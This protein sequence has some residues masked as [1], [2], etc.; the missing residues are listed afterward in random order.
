MKMQIDGFYV[1]DHALVTV[2]I[3]FNV[4]TQGEFHHCTELKVRATLYS[5][6]NSTT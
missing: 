4:L 5:I 3:I 2:I 6:I 1:K